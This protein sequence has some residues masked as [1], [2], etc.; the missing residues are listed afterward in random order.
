[1]KA[2]IICGN[3]FEEIKCILDCF[4]VCCVISMSI[5]MRGGKKNVC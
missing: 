3:V 1:M 2:K 4:P 5:S